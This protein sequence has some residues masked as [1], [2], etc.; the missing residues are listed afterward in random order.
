MTDEPT[1]ANVIVLNIRYITTGIGNRHSAINVNDLI[2]VKCK[3]T[4]GVPAKVFA[5]NDLTI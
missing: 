1:V 3:G 2:A 5:F 4:V